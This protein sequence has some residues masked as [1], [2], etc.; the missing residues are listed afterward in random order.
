MGCSSFVA[1]L[2]GHVPPR[3]ALQF[4]RQQLTETGDPSEPNKQQTDKQTDKK[5][6]KEP[7]KMGILE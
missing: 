1:K 5:W 4:L 7:R 6:K 3:V 2:Q